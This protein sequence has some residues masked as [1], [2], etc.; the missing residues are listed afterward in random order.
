M[1]GRAVNLSTKKSFEHVAGSVTFL[2][3]TSLQ[4]R[5]HS[6]S[7][8]GKSFALFIYEKFRGEG[9][10]IG[11]KIDM[12]LHIISVL[13]ILFIKLQTTFIIK[14]LKSSVSRAFYNKFF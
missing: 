3:I 4:C 7:M 10:E 2:F 5:I 1:I 12:K 9:S 6:F 14:A 13:K 8:L 11:G